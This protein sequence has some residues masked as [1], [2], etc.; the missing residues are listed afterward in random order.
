MN[1]DNLNQYYLELLSWLEYKG[2]ASQRIWHPL[3]YTYPW[4]LRFELGEYAQ[5]DL[6]E[7]V[8]SAKDRGLRIWREVFAPEDDVLVIFETTPDRALKQE[9][10]DCR[11]QRLL[12]QAICPF[13]NQEPDGEKPRYFHRYLYRSG[14]KN[15]PFGAILKRIVEEQ[16]I[17]GG[18]MRYTCHVYF[19]N[20]TKKLLFHPYDDRGADLIGPDRESLRTYYQS[21]YD[22]L[23]DWNREDMKR[24][25]QV[26]PVYLR[27]LTTTME[28]ERVQKIRE[29]LAR[30]LRGARVLREHFEPYWK[31]EG[32][33]EMS[34]AVDSI[35]PLK[36]IQYRLAS[37]WE[38]DSASVK[39]QAE[40]FLPDVGFLWVHE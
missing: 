12:D 6:G 32:W 20:R 40:I 29:K 36:D 9:L 26:R 16:T 3:F 8:Q 28:S 1:K 15:I 33:G 11:M 18:R 34:L 30:K 4:G 19:Y 23:L 35:H 39:N 31:I 2:G 7:Y 25:F 27:I 21:L 13:P 10:K 5:D 14:A 37:K 24:K 22:L 38:S 17:S